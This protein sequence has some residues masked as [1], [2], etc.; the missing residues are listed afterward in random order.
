MSRG[1]W[2]WLVAI[3]ITL[4]FARYQRVTG[5]TQPFAGAT[6]VGG[7]A[8]R[9]TIDRAHPG[10]G[11]H[12]VRVRAEDAAVTGEVAWR[13]HGQRG[14][15]RMTPMQREGGELIARLPN[16]PWGGKLDFRVRLAREGRTVV[17]P[18]SGNLVVRFRGEVPLWVVVPH[19]FA[20]FFAMLFSTRAGL[21]AFRSPARLRGLATWTVVTFFLAGFVFG[22]LMTWYAFGMWWTGFPVGNDPTDNKTT[23]AMIG[24]LLAL[25]FIRRGR[26]DRAWAVTAA[27]VMLLVFAIPHSIAAGARPPDPAD[28]PLWGETAPG[29]QAAL[30]A[31]TAAGDA[32]AAR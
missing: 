28:A 1:F 22:P 23:V 5:P 27:L 19:V 29:G 7:A 20:M 8:I 10:P 32:G 15:W 31:D 14:G 6:T 2:L 30:P 12:P 13:P 9:Y 11:D 26:A 24:W 21:E 18:E 3:L 17:L 4:A 16:Q 25:I